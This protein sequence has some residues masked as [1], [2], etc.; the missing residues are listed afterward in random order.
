MLMDPKAIAGRSARRERR[1]LQDESRHSGSL[2]CWKCPERELCG[3]LNIGVGSM[4]CLDFCCGGKASCD[5]VCRRTPAKYVERYRE[6]G[7]FDLQM[8]PRTPVLGDVKLPSVV[9]VFYHGGARE[10]G[11]AGPVVCLP[12]FRAIAADGTLKA[13]DGSDLRRRFRI[14]ADSQVIMSAT[15]QDDFLESWWNLGPARRREVIR[16]LCDAGV[17]LV[18]TPNY[19]LFTDHPRWDDLHSMKRIALVWEEFQNGGLPAALHVNGRT[20]RDAERWSEFIRQRPEV[21]MLAFE[22]GTGAGRGNRRSL[23]S[24]RLIEMAA[25]ADRPLQLLIRGATEK[26]AEFRQGFGAVSV[27]DTSAFMKTMFRW[28]AVVSGAG[29]LNWERQ[30][31][32]KGA[33]LDA[34]LAQNIKAIESTL[35]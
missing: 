17:A 20:E 10:N 19:S 9:P 32:P 8:V 2:L 12:F 22:F 33:S 24:Q 11:Y 31:T 29:A 25:H 21:K 5:K 1:L 3:G 6:V 16:T 7:G 23:H 35:G 14:G 13:Q 26:V 30:P 34:L 27:L 15:A 18:T 28:R 4:S